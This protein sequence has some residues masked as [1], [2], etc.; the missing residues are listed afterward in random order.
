MVPEPPSPRVFSAPLQPSIWSPPTPASRKE[1][2]HRLS[3]ISSETKIPSHDQNRQQQ[4]LTFSGHLFISCRTHYTLIIS[5]V[6][7]SIPP[8]LSALWKL[9]CVA[10]PQKINTL[11]SR[12]M[13]I[14][15]DMKTEILIGSCTP[16]SQT[17]SR[18]QQ[19]KKIFF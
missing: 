18:H 4:V 13:W 8:V 12:R 1:V 19:F 2:T 7:V 16:F 5:N 10:F 3:P 15:S 11:S 14:F 6:T 9:H 17:N